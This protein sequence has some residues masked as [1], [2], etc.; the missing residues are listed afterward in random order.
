MEFTK[1]ESAGNDY[2]YFDCTGG[3]PDEIAKDIPAAA[4]KLSDRHFGVGGD[5]IVLICK[6]E[7][8]DFRM[9]MFNN[10]GSEGKM[11]G[12][13]SICIGKYV[14][15]H[16]L[17]DKTE[18][19][20][21][22]LSGI[23]TLNL[24]TDGKSVISTS[25]NMGKAILT[26]KEIPVLS[27][28]DTYINKK[29]TLKNGV[30]YTGTAVSMGNPHFVIFTEDEI[31]EEEFLR[32]GKLLEFHKSFPERVNTEFV[33]IRDRSHLKM[34][35]WER[36]TGE[37]L[38]CGTGTCA[39]VV[40]AVINNYADYDAETEVE[41]RGGKLLVTYKEDGTVILKGFGRESFSGNVYL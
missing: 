21:E 41:V 17:T 7:A 14:Y 23:K 36:G 16:G 13:A 4:I 32:D 31:S 26:A 35:V 5:G 33:T 39:T 19:T 1:M 8:S 2:V 15:E 30:R 29:I 6:S 24:E 11:C 40:A 37:T 9:R 38:A 18:V 20:L 3:I 27:D 12:N 34:R 22:T 25:V 10:D 28:E